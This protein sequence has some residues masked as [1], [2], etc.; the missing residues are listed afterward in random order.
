MCFTNLHPLHCT[1]THFIQ[2][3]VCTLNEKCLLLQI[4]SKLL[5]FG[6]FVGSFV[7]LNLLLTG[8]NLVG[9]ILR[10]M[11][12]KTDSCCTLS[13]LL[14]CMAGV[15][16]PYCNGLNDAQ[17]DLFHQ[18]AHPSFQY[19]LFFASP[20]LLP[21]YWLVPLVLKPMILTSPSARYLPGIQTSQHLTFLLCPAFT[22][23]LPN[24]GLCTCS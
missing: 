13:S 1:L 14:F 11:Q 7:L 4:Q 2:N 21:M 16:A 3:P 8:T 22:Q 12:G 5:Q 6:S 23:L 19:L 24:Y 15:S 10:R 20:Q 17:R 9:L 18:P